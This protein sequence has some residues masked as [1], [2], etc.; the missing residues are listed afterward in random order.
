MFR[1]GFWSWANFK[2]PSKV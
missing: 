1:F 2:L